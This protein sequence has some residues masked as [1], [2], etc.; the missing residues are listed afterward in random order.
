MRAA[1][2]PRWGFGFVLKGSQIPGFKALVERRGTAGFAARAAGRGL[3]LP[4]L[5][6][7]EG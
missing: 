4:G 7:Q 6:P 3:C 5:G 1:R 2:G